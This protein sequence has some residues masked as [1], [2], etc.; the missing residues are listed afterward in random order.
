[1]FFGVV[2]GW[3]ATLSFSANEAGPVRLVM[4]LRIAHDSFGS[5]SDPSLN[6]NLHYP[7]N[8]DRSLK[9]SDDDKIRKYPADYN[10]KPP[11]TVSFMTPISSTSGRLHSEF[12]RFF[13]LRAHR[14]TDRFLASSGLRITLNL[15]GTPILVKTAVLRITLNLDG[16]SITSKSHSP[17][18][19]AN[20]SYINLDCLVFN[21]R[22]SINNK[23]KI[24]F[25]KET[26]MRYLL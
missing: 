14:E 24:F 15:G 4:D 12:V 22:L 10:N 3:S 26:P 17:I 16:V 6:G 20:I 18:T 7:N 9:E 2:H 13:I 5:P 23:Q 11:N 25:A 8:I 1:M 21:S 19:L